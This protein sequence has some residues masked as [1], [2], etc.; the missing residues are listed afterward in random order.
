MIPITD[1]L[2]RQTAG[3]DAAQLYQFPMTDTAAGF[4]TDTIDFH[5][6]AFEGYG[7]RQDHSGTPAVGHDGSALRLTEIAGP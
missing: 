7:G 5:D 3:R 1:C 2:V 4:V 6:F